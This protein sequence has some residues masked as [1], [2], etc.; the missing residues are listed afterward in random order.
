MCYP[1]N[2]DHEVKYTY[3]YMYLLIHHDEKRKAKKKDYKILK[4]EQEQKL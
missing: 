4:K 1:V 3:Q 2:L